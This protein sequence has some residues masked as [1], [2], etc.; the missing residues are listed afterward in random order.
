MK[1]T[2]MIEKKQDDTAKED[3]E[4]YI[5]DYLNQSDYYIATSYQYQTY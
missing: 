4:E 1:Y 2:S 3:S 5:S